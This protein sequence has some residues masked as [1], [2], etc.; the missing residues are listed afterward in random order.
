MKEKCCGRVWHAIGN[1]HGDL[2]GCSRNASVER[3]GKHYCKQHDPEAANARRAASQAKWEREMDLKDAENRRARLEHQACMG[4]T[5]E[6]LSDLP[7]LVKKL[8]EERDELKAYFGEYAE[9]LQDLTMNVM[10]KPCAPVSHSWPG[11][12]HVECIREGVM[13]L[14]QQLGSL[15]AENER[16]RPTVRKLSTTCTCERCESINTTK[17]PTP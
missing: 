11:K 3:D 15:K 9:T 4:C 12:R 8:K 6:E 2:S 1:G 16:L 5:D 10:Y 14:L 7:A 17:E 13:E